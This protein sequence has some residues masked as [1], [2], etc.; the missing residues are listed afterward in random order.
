VLEVSVLSFSGVPRKRML[1]GDVVAEIGD[2][3]EEEGAEVVA[4]ESRNSCCVRA[5][6]F[7]SLCSQIFFLLEVE[8][9]KPMEMLAQGM[10]ERR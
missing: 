8:K 5:A 9:W 3:G 2:R 10:M 4:Q 6:I 1:G 7:K